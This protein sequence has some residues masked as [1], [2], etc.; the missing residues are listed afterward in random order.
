MGRPREQADQPT[1]QVIAVDG[2]QLATATWGTGAP[3]IVML[4]DGLGSVAQWRSVP[5]DLANRTGLTVMAYDRAGHGSSI[6]VPSGPWPADW[7]H[8]EA[9]VLAALLGLVGAR[10]PVLVGHSDGGSIAAILAAAQPTS[11]RQLALLAAHTWVETA[12]VREIERMRATPSPIVAALRRFHDRPEELFEA[13]SGVW[14]SEEF[15]RWDIRA[16]VADIEVPTIVIQGAHDEYATDAHAFETSGAIG[17]NARPVLL[18]DLG[19]LLHHQAPDVVAEL[20]AG[21][22]DA[23]R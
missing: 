23:G 10:D 1:R 14:V 4:H 7:L 12:T 5:A 3:E 11:C 2:Q 18:P 13:W 21:F 19:H 9:E 17:S 20:V 22:V 16:L 8:R 15:A 6:P